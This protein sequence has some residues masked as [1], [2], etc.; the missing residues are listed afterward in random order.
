M[1]VPFALLIALTTLAPGAFAQ[2]QYSSTLISPIFPPGT[3]PKIRVELG[4][5][6]A[7]YNIT[8]F[9]LAAAPYT[10]LIL[11]CMDP[12]QASPADD[13]YTVRFARTG[14]TAPTYYDAWAGLT[15]AQR[16]GRVQNLAD[17]FKANIPTVSNMISLQIAV[18]EITNETSSTY[19]LDSG[20]F[21]ASKISG[22]GQ[23][24]T[25]II[26]GAKTML[27][28]LSTSAV[29]GKGNINHL[30]FLVDG[31]RVGTS[32]LVQDL[33]VYMPPIPEPAHYAL[34]GSAAL[35][36]LVILRRRRR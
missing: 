29:Q 27:A 13:T 11:F 35:A 25:D 18:W 24:A 6:V 26:N 4:T 28:S 1:K 8:P 34:G 36:A 14:A 30:G 20:H 22:T 9:T 17:L 5:Q 23:V 7:D 3:N 32:T 21:E 12:M 2:V 15:S 33:V 31:T 16:D 19:S 10:S